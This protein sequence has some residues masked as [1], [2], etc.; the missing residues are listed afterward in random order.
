MLGLI[1]SFNLDV[2]SIGNLM[3]HFT[4][5]TMVYCVAFGCKNRLTK[6]C[7]IHFFQFPKDVPRRRKWIHYC[8]RA[9]FTEATPSSTLCSKHFSSDQFERD[10]LKLAQFGYKN[11]RPKLKNDAVPDIHINVEEAISQSRKRPADAK[12]NR[13]ACEKRRR[14]EVSLCVYV[15]LSIIRW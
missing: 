9:D 8:R 15:S 6:G 1:A 7:D 13:R 4:L 3:L 10:P 14:A 2:Y 12:L 11:A 5:I